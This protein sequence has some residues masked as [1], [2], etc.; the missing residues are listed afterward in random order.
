MG[1]QHMQPWQR[2]ELGRRAGVVNRKLSHDQVKSIRETTGISDA[3]FANDF[4]V[5]TQTITAA[6]TGAS[7]K[8]HPSKPRMVYGRRVAS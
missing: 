5:D 4:D 3:A 1:F 8:D 6:R 2:E 7:Y